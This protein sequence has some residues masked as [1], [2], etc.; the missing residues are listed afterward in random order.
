MSAGIQSKLRGESRGVQAH[1][2]TV[3]YLESQEGSHPCL[4]CTGVFLGKRGSSVFPGK[5]P[6]QARQGRDPSWDLE[7]FQKVNCFEAGLVL[8]VS[9]SS[10]TLV[11]SINPG[12]LHCFI[13]EENRKL[14]ATPQVI[15]F[16]ETGKLFLR[17]CQAIFC[18]IGEIFICTSRCCNCF[19]S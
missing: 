13:K 15:T 18:S 1:L 4:A 9:E 6:V 7:K 12:F 17:K 5:T 11:L 2:K 16:T 19:V 14:D 8:P 3:Y 10:T